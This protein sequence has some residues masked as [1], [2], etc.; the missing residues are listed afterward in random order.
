MMTAVQP[1][2]D[3]IRAIDIHA[4]VMLSTRPDGQEESALHGAARRFLSS[5]EP[6][7][8][9][10]D[11]ADYF[12][13]RNMMAVVFPV[14]SKTGTGSAGVPSEEVADLAMAH[15]DVLI[16]FASVD[17]WDGKRAVEQVRRLAEQFGVRGFKFHPITQAFFPNDQ[18]FY[19]IYEA[20]ESYGL[21]SLFHTGQ[22]MMG[23]SLPGGGGIRLKYAN[24]IYL[25]DVA[26]DFPN[27]PLIMAHPSVPWQDEALS[28]ALHKRQVYIDLSGWSPKYFPSQLVQYANTLLKHKILYGSDYPLFTPDRWLAD[29]EQ[30]PFRDEVRPLILKYNAARLLGL[31]KD[32]EEHAGN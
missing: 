16:P 31:L 22:T 18:Q 25:D 6:S 28:I 29:F 23:R 32:S 17:P 27:M 1:D 15:S 4:H 2:L 5:G 10:H 8:T 11:V 3:K 14:N 21:I 19:P 12:R 13:R 7:P 26:A 30:A 24:P 9:V 20:I